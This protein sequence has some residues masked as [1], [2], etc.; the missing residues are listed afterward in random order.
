MLAGNHRVLHTSPH[1]THLPLVLSA[2][3]CF[4][5]AHENA[6]IIYNTIFPS[7][8][9]TSLIYFGSIASGPG[10]LRVLEWMTGRSRLDPS[11]AMLAW[12]FA[13]M[14]ARGDPTP[15][16]VASYFVGSKEGS[17]QRQCAFLKKI[18]ESR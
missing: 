6:V 18:Q 16:M 15:V 14:A 3:K 8:G 11:S 5:K 13:R 7:T 17:H 2:K 10:Y 9:L 4:N 12:Y 1:N